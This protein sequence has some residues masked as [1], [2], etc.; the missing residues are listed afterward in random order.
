MGDMG[1]DRETRV[2]REREGERSPGRLIF[3]ALLIQFKE[4]K[5]SKMKKI[6]HKKIHKR[7]QNIT[8]QNNK[9]I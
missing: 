5:E 2:R 7:R 9:P 3:F 8:I 6:T 4:Y 1:R